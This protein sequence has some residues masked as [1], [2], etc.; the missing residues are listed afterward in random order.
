V[1]VEIGIDEDGFTIPSY[2]SVI[3]ITD[4]C[5]S[6]EHI[7]VTQSPSA[8]SSVAPGSTSVVLTAIDKS[9]NKKT[10]TFTLKVTKS[11]TSAT[12]ATTHASL[13]GTDE[14]IIVSHGNVQ[15]W[16]AIVI[17]VLIVGILF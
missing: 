9:G 12:S 17:I 6:A 2:N 10:C 15:E 5:D 7:N 14:S 8:G 13:N 11:S 16:R 1:N 4:N 3:T